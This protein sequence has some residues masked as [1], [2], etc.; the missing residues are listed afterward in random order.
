MIAGTMLQVAGGLW[1]I[2]SGLTEMGR[3]SAERLRRMKLAN[4]QTLGSATAMG[5]A[6]GVEFTSESIQRHL[7]TMASEFQ[8][9]ETDFQYGADQA[10]TNMAMSTGLN[11]LSDVGK[12]VA[13]QG[14]A[15]N[16][17]R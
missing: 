11:M 4:A 3:L 17:W 1:S 16:W 12:G 9:Q 13:D 7:Q 14:K 15:D 2:G 10:A 8:K 6:S 5:A